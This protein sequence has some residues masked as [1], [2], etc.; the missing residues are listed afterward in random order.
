MVGDLASSVWHLR[1]LKLD[2]IVISGQTPYRYQ[3][4]IAVPTEHAILDKLLAELT[5]TEVTA[6][7]QRWISSPAEQPPFWRALLIFGLPGLIAALLIIFTVMRIN[8]RLHNE[9]QQR[10]T[11]VNRAFTSIT[12]Y[13]EAEALGSSPRLIASGRHDSAF[14]S[15]MWH[16]LSV[17]GNWQGKV[18]NKRKKRRNPPR[19]VD[20][21]RGARQRP[22]DHPLCRRIRRLSSL[23]NAQASLDHQAHL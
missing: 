7:E 12:G 16:S 15:A 5:P 14:Y 13:S 23:K 6:I 18:W 21:Q 3:L 19:M 8:H 20:Y 1:Q 9:M 22:R 2:G 4:A 11:A 10:I 17:S